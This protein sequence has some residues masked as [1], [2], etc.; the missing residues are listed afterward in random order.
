[1]GIVPEKPT[2][3]IA[4]YQNRANATGAFK[5]NAVAVGTTIVA[6]DALNTLADDAYAAWQE[7]QLKKDQAKVATQNFKQALTEMSTAGSDILKAIK[8]KAAV[9]GD[10]IYTLANLPA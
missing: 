9:G 1:M 8:A 2:D 3:R 6:V 10:G 5:L 4:F 7:Q